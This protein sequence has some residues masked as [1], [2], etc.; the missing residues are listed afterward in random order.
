MGV[1]LRLEKKIM[2]TIPQISNPITNKSYSQNSLLG[3]QPGGAGEQFDIIQLMNPLEAASVSDREAGRQSALLEQKDFLPMS[4]KLT[5]DPTMAVESLKQILNNDLLAIAKAN[6][7]TELY[8]ELEELMKSVFLKPDGLLSEILSQE[9]ST[10]LFGDDKFFNLL[11]QIMAEGA[12]K[13][14]A[15]ELKNAIGNML[16]AVNYSRNQQ[17]ILSALSSN[18]KFMSQYFTPNKA[19]SEDLATLAARWA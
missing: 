17:E 16:K 4:V 7:Y 18:M 15:E 13:A 11:R 9:K 8:G 1:E 3:K 12:G 2:P 19:L 5:K 10:T 6:G 14:N